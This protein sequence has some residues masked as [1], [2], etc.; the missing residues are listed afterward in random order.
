MGKA[1]ALSRRGAWRHSV[2]IAMPR[3]RR[4]MSAVAPEL[5]TPR[6]GDHSHSVQQV[7]VAGVRVDDGPCS[8]IPGP[9]ITLTEH[10]LE[11]ADVEVWC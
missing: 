11:D 10:R 9:G 7:D 2:S 1:I 4:K 8:P 5:R 3:L 6:A